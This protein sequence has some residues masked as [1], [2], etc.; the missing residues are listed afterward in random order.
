MVLHRVTACAS[1]AAVTNWYHDAAVRVAPTEE[2]VRAILG[3]R[4]AERLWADEKHAEW[5]AACRPFLRH[6]LSPTLVCPK[7]DELARRNILDVTRLF[8]TTL[9]AAAASLPD[10]ATYG[11]VPVLPFLLAAPP[12]MVLPCVINEDFWNMVERR[13]PPVPQVDPGHEAEAPWV[14]PR[15]RDLRRR[16]QGVM[17]D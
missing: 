3:A 8:L 2:L 1:T 12:D 9:D 17:P 16:G 7:H 15:R 6:L 14:R 13:M 11:G 10:A 5:E 4:A